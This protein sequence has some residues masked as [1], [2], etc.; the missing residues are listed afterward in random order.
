MEES[1]EG[2]QAV[3]IVPARMESRRLAGRPLLPL[4]E[5]TV[6]EQVLRR[7]RSTK[8]GV[9]VVV[10]TTESDADKPLRDICAGRGVRCLTEQTGDLLDCALHA[11]DSFS[12]QA[13]VFCPDSKPLVFPRMLDA[14]ARYALEA[15]VDYVTVGRLP[16]GS[17]VEAL[18]VSTLRRIAAMTRAPEHRNRVTEFAAAHP[19]LF[20]RAYLPSPPRFARP[21]AN[22]LLETTGDYRFL[23]RIYA[24][25]APRE[26]GLL[27]IEDVLSYLDAEIELKQAA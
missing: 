12:A 18:P 9:N 10:V 7:V 13:V 3:V 14:C 4:G 24:E 23:C 16:E 17:A 1:F 25:V 20:D 8:F 5:A 2:A 15:T 6:L 26:N 19:D 11:A 22:F 27:A 21:D